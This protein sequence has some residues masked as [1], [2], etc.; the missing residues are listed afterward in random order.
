MWLVMGPRHFI[1]AD[2]GVTPAGLGMLAI[3]CGKTVARARIALCPGRVTGRSV[4]RFAWKMQYDL[5]C[6]RI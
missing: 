4:Y 1:V 2:I 5:V 3:S 6:F